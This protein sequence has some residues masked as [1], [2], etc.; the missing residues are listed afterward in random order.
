LYKNVL[1][2]NDM[3]KRENSHWITRYSQ[4]KREKYYSII[5]HKNLKCRRIY[6]PFSVICRY[7]LIKKYMYINMHVRIEK[8]KEN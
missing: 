5:I 6:V 8:E 7:V 1:K 4:K 2:S 3:R